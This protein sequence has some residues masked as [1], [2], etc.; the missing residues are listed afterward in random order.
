[1]QWATP[2][3]GAVVPKGDGDVKDAVMGPIQPAQGPCL[4]FPGWGS[5]EG[6]VPS[7][8][9]QVSAQRWEQPLKCGCWL[10][11]S[12]EAHHLD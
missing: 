9:T 7:P 6:D 10:I 5:P 3:D 2:A 12:P 8:N 11:P 4:L 1:L